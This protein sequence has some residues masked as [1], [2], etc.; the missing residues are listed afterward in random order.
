MPQLRESKDC[1][2]AL[3]RGINKVKCFFRE[4]TIVFTPEQSEKTPILLH[5]NINPKH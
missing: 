4:Q 5:S 1:L 2:Q 3:P